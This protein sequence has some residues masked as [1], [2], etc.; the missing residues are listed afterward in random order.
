MCVCVHHSFFS[1]SSVNGHSGC[2]P[3]LAI[4]VVQSL[5]HAWLFGI[6]WTAAC[7]ASLSFTVSRS[8]L[9]LCPLSQWCHPIISSS[10]FPFS[11]CLRSFFSESAL[12][13]GWPKYWSFSFSISPVNIQGWFPL[14]LTGFISLQSRTLNSQGATGGWVDNSM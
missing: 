12:N 5:S 14:G 11:F 13:I 10:A 7:Q 4:M 1:H 9:K 6:P 3:V 2:F 8:L